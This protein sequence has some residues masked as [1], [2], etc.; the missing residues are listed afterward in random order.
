M[1][2]VSFLDIRVR[3][4]LNKW[5]NLVVIRE[6][7][8]ANRKL[9]AGMLMEN[10]KY[11]EN[12]NVVRRR[13]KHRNARVSYCLTGWYWWFYTLADV[14]NNRE[15]KVR[16]N[17]YYYL[18]KILLNYLELAEPFSI[19]CTHRAGWGQCQLSLADVF[20]GIGK[21]LRSGLEQNAPLEKIG[22]S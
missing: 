21:S 18:L 9:K 4:K 20:C 14:L 19:R 3:S 1:Y 11:C 17:P 8:I 13:K 6:Q 10:I 2:A 15:G 5:C 12:T 22:K 7:G 16:W